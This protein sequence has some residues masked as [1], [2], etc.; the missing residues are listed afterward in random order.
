MNKIHFPLIYLAYFLLLIYFSIFSFQI[1]L[2][3]LL[4]F[5]LIFPI[6][7]RRYL[8][9]LVLTCFSAYFFWVKQAAAFEKAHQPTQIS[10]ISPMI[11]S[12]QLNGNQLSFQA[13]SDHHKFQVYYLLKQKL[14]KIT[15]KNLIK[16]VN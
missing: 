1:P 10:Q 6:K 9:L 2:L 5:S 15:F 14:K 7:K 13:S 12:L 11:D 3:F 4:V 8:V 16:I